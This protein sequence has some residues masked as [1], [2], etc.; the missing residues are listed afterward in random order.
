MAYLIE[1]ITKLTNEWYFLIDKDHHKDRDCHWRIETKWSYG[2]PPIYVIVHHGYIL[3]DIA[4]EH[5]SY[6]DALIAL[7]NLLKEKIQEEIKINL[8]N[9]LNNEDW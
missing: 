8:I 2:K 1:E 3:G 6:E 5:G 9:T 4:E 7:V